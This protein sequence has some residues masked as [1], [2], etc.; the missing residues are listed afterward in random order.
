MNLNLFPNQ[1]QHNFS[2]IFVSLPWW[3]FIFYLRHMNIHSSLQWCFSLLIWQQSHKQII[4]WICVIFKYI[5]GLKSTKNYQA[6]REFFIQI[7]SKV[8]VLVY[9]MFGFWKNFM[10]PSSSTCHLS[11]TAQTAVTDL[12]NCWSLNYWFNSLFME[13]ITYNIHNLRFCKPSCG[14]YRHSCV[15]CYAYVTCKFSSQG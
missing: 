11:A 8:F 5:F 6:L 7:L 2:I 9:L 4:H 15:K 13:W 10:N 12:H 1:F 3:V 14:A